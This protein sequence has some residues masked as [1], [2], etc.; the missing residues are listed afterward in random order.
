MLK[1]ELA[2][3]LGLLSLIEMAER[4]CSLSCSVLPAVIP[5]PKLVLEVA[6]Y[7]CLGCLEANTNTHLLCYSQLHRDS[8]AASHS[9]IS[10]QSHHFT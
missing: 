4:I 1:K 8:F 3:N 7:Y 10:A 9:Q 6:C 5:V 2:V